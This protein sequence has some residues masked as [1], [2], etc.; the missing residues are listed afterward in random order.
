MIINPGDWI[1][2]DVDGVVAVPPSI[3]ENCLKLCEERAAI[4][5]K[6]REALERGDEMGPTIARLRK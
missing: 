4:D 3:A 6:T 1:V 5:E 2:A